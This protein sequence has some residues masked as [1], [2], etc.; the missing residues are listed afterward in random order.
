MSLHYTVYS[1]GNVWLV[2]SEDCSLSS[3]YFP[4]DSQVYAFKPVV[5]GIKISEIYNIDPSMKQVVR[6]YGSWR[7]KR[8]PTRLMLDPSPLFE[9]R[10]DLI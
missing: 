6:S 9:R 3:I 10:N 4:I 7:D 1:K 2:M 8:N 5:D